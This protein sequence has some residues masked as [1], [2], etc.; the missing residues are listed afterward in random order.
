MHAKTHI[1][2]NLHRLV[3]IQYIPNM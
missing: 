1:D 2:I 3:L